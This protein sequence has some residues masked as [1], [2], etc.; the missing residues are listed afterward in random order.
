MIKQLATFALQSYGDAYADSLRKAPTVSLTL[1]YK[2][3]NQKKIRKMRRQ[4]LKV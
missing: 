4:G 2:K 3:K 1:G